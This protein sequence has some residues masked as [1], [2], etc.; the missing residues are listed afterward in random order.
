[1]DAK[2]V[3]EMVTVVET[4]AK[5]GISTVKEAVMPD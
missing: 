2:R 5:A 1:M 4:C 3:R